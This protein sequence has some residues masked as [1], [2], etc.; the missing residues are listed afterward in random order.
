MAAGTSA[1][2][3]PKSK[4]IVLS[5][6]L[7]TRL[8]SVHLQVGC[9][10]LVDAI[11]VHPIPPR[12][13]IREASSKEIGGAAPNSPSAP[14]KEPVSGGASALATVVAA[15]NTTEENCGEISNCLAHFDLSRAVRKEGGNY[16]DAG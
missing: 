9:E 16:G 15:P 7:M 3:P 4:K 1:K 10:T 13:A 8:D 2:V 14:G 11:V 6:I 12:G 5:T